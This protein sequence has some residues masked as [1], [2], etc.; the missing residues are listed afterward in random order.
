VQLI[1][2]PAFVKLR[3]QLMQQN[4]ENKYLLKTLQ[5]ILMMLPQSKSFDVLKTRLDCINI[6]SF[7]VS[8][9]DQEALPV[10]SAEQVEEKQKNNKKEILECLKNFYLQ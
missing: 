5:G 8:F 4:E 3:M 7:S 2:S 6:T 10:L 9:M 1:E